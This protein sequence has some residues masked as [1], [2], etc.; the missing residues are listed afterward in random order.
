[1]HRWHGR[2]LATANGNEKRRGSVGQINL[3]WPRIGLAGGGVRWRIFAPG[4]SFVNFKNWYHR[5]GFLKYQVSR[6]N[7]RKVI[8]RIFITI[9]RVEASRFQK[10]EITVKSRILERRIEENVGSLEKKKKKKVYSV[11][12]SHCFRPTVISALP[13]PR[14]SYKTIQCPNITKKISRLR[15]IVTTSG[16][17]IGRPSQGTRL[18][19]I[20]WWRASRTLTGRTLVGRNNAAFQPRTGPS[21]RRSRRRSSSS[22]I[23]TEDRVVPV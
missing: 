1:M 4:G 11:K 3:N 5:N 19:I 6:V 9:S 21:R 15:R 10:M 2:G 12:S 16:P 17:F 7:Y 8:F 22:K 23:E 14:I 20:R 13:V 18:V